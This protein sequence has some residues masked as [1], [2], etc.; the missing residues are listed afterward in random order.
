MG[1][2]YGQFVDAEIQAIFQRLT[3]DEFK[4]LPGVL[5]EVGATYRGFDPEG[6]ARWIAIEHGAQQQ[7]AV[8]QKLRTPNTYAK[9][10]AITCPVLVLA[11]GADLYAPPALMKL[12]ANHLPRHEWAVLAE[13]GHAINWEQPEAFNERVIAFLRGAGWPMRRPSSVPPSSPCSRPSSRRKPRL[14]P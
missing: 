4:R 1:A 5:R 2:S 6:A 3:P 8:A 13:A 12:W 10:A 7:G 11:G 9:L 14:R